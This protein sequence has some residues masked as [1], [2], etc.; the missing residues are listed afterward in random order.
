MEG[1]YDSSEVGLGCILPDLTD[2]DIDE[3]T[4]HVIIIVIMIMVVGKLSL[5]SNSSSRHRKQF[6]PSSEKVV[7]L[8]RWLFF[9][10][11]Y[12]HFY[13]HFLFAF[14]YLHSLLSIL[15]A[16]CFGLSRWFFISINYSQ[17]F[18]GNFVLANLSR[19]L[20]YFK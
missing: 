14:F 16:I 15:L 4:T 20:F 17:F 18:I 8:S 9:A 11:F 6:A 7:N 3:V 1:W 13:L 10:F 19:W 5:K 2:H 12:L